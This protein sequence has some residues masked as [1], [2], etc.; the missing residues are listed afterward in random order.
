MSRK[1][2]AL[3]VIWEQVNEDHGTTVSDAVR[4]QMTLDLYNIDH[5]NDEAD[6][7]DLIDAMEYGSD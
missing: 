2:R 6:L 4:M 5:P 7:S 3:L 1:Y